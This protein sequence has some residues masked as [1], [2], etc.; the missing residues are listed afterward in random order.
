[1]YIIGVVPTGV[2]NVLSEITAV[3]LASSTVTV[4]LAFTSRTPVQLPVTTD[5]L[6][7]FTA[8]HEGKT[9]IRLR[10]SATRVGQ[11]LR[12]ERSSED[13]DQAR[14]LIMSTVHQ[15]IRM[16]M[17]C[18]YELQVGRLD[19]SKT[20]DIRHMQSKNSWNEAIRSLRPHLRDRVSVRNQ[21]SF[22]AVHLPSCE[23]ERA[24]TQALIT[25]MEPPG[26]IGNIGSCCLRE[27]R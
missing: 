22:G 15:P 12:S 23:G 6:D 1:M 17:L 16:S 9:G 11:E 10:G 19:A 20:C 27:A 14:W 5:A 26:T 8:S 4:C 2:A 24:Q 7:A 3:E 13:S 25:A 18:S 21:H